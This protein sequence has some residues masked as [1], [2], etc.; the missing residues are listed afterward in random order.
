[1]APRKSLICTKDDRYTHC[2]AM[3]MLSQPWHSQP[4]EKISLPAEEINRSVHFTN[5]T[6]HHSL[7]T[8]IDFRSIQIADYVLE[9]QFG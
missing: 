8:F 5:K 2:M 4:T 9:A 7:K 3:M 6:I 1:M